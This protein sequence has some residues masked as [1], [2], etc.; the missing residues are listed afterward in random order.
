MEGKARFLL[1]GKKESI[2]KTRVRVCVECVARVVE[3]EAV[4]GEEEVGELGDDLEVARVY[5]VP[6]DDAELERVR[7]VRPGGLE[8][9]SG[10]DLRVQAD[11][12]GLP[13]T[14]R[15]RSAISFSV[16]L[17]YV[18]RTPILGLF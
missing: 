3:V 16:H 18:S 1:V 10:A 4:V 9:G 17:R 5:A 11:G 7:E 14:H 12:E 6:V 13:P 2:E 15:Y 8:L